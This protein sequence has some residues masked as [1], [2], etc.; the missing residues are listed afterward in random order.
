MQTFLE[1]RL[2]LCSL[3]NFGVFATGVDGVGI[4]D[5]PRVRK[6]IGVDFSERD[7]VSGTIKDGKPTIGKP[8]IG[9]V[10]HAPV[11]VMASPI[12]NGSGKVIGVL[13]GVVSLG[14]PNF[15]DQITTSRHGKTGG[16]LLVAP[17]FRLIVTASD[18]RRIMET[19]PAPGANPLI[20]EFIEGKEWS[21]AILA[22][23][24]VEFLVSSARIPA[25]DW[26]AIA[27]LPINEAFAPIRDMQRRMLFA[28]VLLTLLAGLVLWWMLR[29]QLSPLVSTAKTLAA[30]S[31]VDQPLQP[32][33]IARE[34]E[35]GQL[36]AGFNRLLE[37]IG[38][39]DAA[40]R[41]SEERFKALHD[42]SFG[43]IAI[44][45]QGI[46]LDCNQSLVELSGYGR[47]ELIGMNGL[48]LIA[49]EFRQKVIE[50]MRK[51]SEDPYDAEGILKDGTRRQFSVCGK[52]IPFKGKTVRVTEFR[53]I[54]ERK[55]MEQALQDSLRFAQQLVE[56]IPSPVFY[57]NSEGRYLG[58]NEAFEHYLGKAR[59]SFIGKSVYDLSP[60]D[61]AERYAAADQYLFDHPGT[62]IYEAVVQWADGSRHNVVFHKATFMRANGQL[63][64]LVGV[65][66][67]IT[68]RK[69]LE[70]EMIEH[71]EELSFLNKR[72]EEA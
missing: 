14:A 6:R 8:I 50:N 3:F 48:D 53:D 42:A 7:Y 4:A 34:D 71:I 28:T 27:M 32:L 39:G 35:I 47:E 17:R 59:Q 55:R 62:Q 41:E 56:A 21:A 64:G 5:V 43:G 12:K 1:Q 54:T 60:K 65:I 24:G 9:K 58:C 70:S 13:A 11:L 52:N 10:V 30:M 67:D 2:V 23:N 37:I 26:Q 15:L 31:S 36:V 25:G 69:Q 49:P 29:Y 40:L 44:H 18:K 66:L 45:E 22:Q 20:D 72:L 16:Y 63:G 38:K 46:I 33:A 61:L 19:L 68:E 51:G 57:K